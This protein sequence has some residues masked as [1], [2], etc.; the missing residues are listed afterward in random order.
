LGVLSFVG[1]T[2]LRSRLRSRFQV[3]AKLRSGRTTEAQDTT[4]TGTG[5]Q[6]YD[7]DYQERDRPGPTTAPAPP[8]TAFDA[9]EDNRGALLPGPCSR[10]RAPEAGA[11]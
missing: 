4:N 11:G 1:A 2:R 3:R 9:T 6:C 7:Y 8:S 5:T 10:H